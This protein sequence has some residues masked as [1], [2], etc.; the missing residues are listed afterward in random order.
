MRRNSTKERIRKICKLAGGIIDQPDE[1]ER[2]VI[3]SHGGDKSRCNTISLRISNVDELIEKSMNYAEKTVS[4][5]WKY[6]K[7]EVA[8]KCEEVKWEHAMAIFKKT[9]RNYFKGGIAFDNKLKTAIPEGDINGWCLL[10]ST[11]NT[12]STPREKNLKDY[13]KQRFKKEYSWPSTTDAKIYFFQTKS[14]I[15]D[16]EEVHRI[17][18]HKYY[19]G[20]REIDDWE[21]GKG[22]KQSIEKS[23]DYLASQINET[24][25]YYYGR[26]PCFDK[27][28]STYNTL[29]HFSSTYALIEGWELTKNSEHIRKA[30]LALDWGINN[31]TLLRPITTDNGLTNARF[32]T[33][34]NDEIKLGACAHAILATCKYIELTGDIKYEKIIK[35]LALSITY[36][37]DKAKEGFVHVLNQSDL[38]T[39]EI[40]R[41]IY[42]DGEAL[43]ALCKA[44]QV[45]KDKSFLDSAVKAANDFI[46]SQ[47]WKAHDHWLAYAFNELYE[48]KD[49]TKYVD[50][51]LKNISSHLTFIDQ[52]ITTY[53]TLLELC[54]ATNCLIEKAR[55]RDLDKFIDKNIDHSFFKVAMK[56]RARYLMNGFFWPEIA[57]HYKKPNSILNSFFIRHHGFRTRIDDNEH[58]ISGLC[59]YYKYTKNK[60]Q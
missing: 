18:E 36:C 55:E 9:K 59:A 6:I 17:S 47:H 58:Y 1:K 44:Y 21:N 16:G 46:K 22:I 41:I 53:P 38:S 37:Q 2:T 34:I 29:R 45:L 33:E 40:S 14:W 60:T 26:W 32:V 48:I 15:D 24:G 57:M 43:F 11:N 7:L 52:R 12:Y 50:F 28:I 25:E 5:E 31:Y 20:Y 3:I 8:I 23:T 13:C 42:Y 4:A 19:G 54:M 56:H 30:E 10:Y 35:E 39:K 51:T 27:E 49:E